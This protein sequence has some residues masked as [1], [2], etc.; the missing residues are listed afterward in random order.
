MRLL[1]LFLLVLATAVC[2]RRQVP[3][4]YER[5][6]LRTRFELG[7]RWTWATCT[8][9][10]TCWGRAL[11]WT[12][13]TRECCGPV[14][15][16]G[17]WMGRYRIRLLLL[18]LPT[19]GV[20]RRRQVPCVFERHC[21]RVHDMSWVSTGCGQRAHHQ[22]RAGAERC[23]RLLQLLSLTHAVILSFCLSRGWD[24]LGSGRCCCCCIVLLA[25]AVCAAG[26]RSLRCPSVSACSVA[27]LPFLSL[28]SALQQG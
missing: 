10:A 22:P 25:A 3:L 8:P 26:T 11:R 9:S 23:A 21:L 16:C 20:C 12:T 15:F 18:L 13:T 19:T 24:I 6:C 4:M 17:A 14:Y 27:L 2:C 5:H 1:L 28:P 7:V